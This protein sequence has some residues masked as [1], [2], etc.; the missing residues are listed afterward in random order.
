M[1]TYFTSFKIYVYNIHAFITHRLFLNKYPLAY[2]L[3]STFYE[4]CGLLLTKQLNPLGSVLVRCVPMLEKRTPN[5]TLNSV[6]DILILI[7]L[8]TE[9]N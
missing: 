9:V 8:F 7:P 5:F 6:L 4:H 1:A 2:Q 3:G